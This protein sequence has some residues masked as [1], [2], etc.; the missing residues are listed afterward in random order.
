VSN[1][2]RL[3][4]RVDPKPFLDEI[5]EDHFKIETGRQKNVNE[6]R[7]TESIFL[8]DTPLISP[9][10]RIAN[11]QDA[12]NTPLY[13]LYP[14]TTKYLRDFAADP[15]RG[16]GHLSRV[17]IA[18]LQPKSVIDEHVDV[19]MYHVV[20]KRYHVVLKSTSGSAM[21]ISGQDFLWKE[22]EVYW[23][24]NNITHNARNDSDEWR[25]HIIFDIIPF[26][27]LEMVRQFRAAYYD[28]LGIPQFIID[29]FRYL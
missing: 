10:M 22:G 26:D 20:R 24:N 7:Y 19:G 15:E 9:L 23:F 14:Y 29:D 8:R 4:E 25:I 16:N 17:I 11:T 18:R 12:R 13:K 27:R 6:Q 2:C 1:R 21:N 28:A 3:I 5:V